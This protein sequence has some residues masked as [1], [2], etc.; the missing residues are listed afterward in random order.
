[1]VLYKARGEWQYGRFFVPVS[2][3]QIK[4]LFWNA[5]ALDGEGDFAEDL[6]FEKV[7]KALKNL[8]SVQVTD[9]KTLAD[10]LYAGHMGNPSQARFCLYPL[11]GGANPIRH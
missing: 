3:D 8:G 7:K 2:F 1:M 11:T 9:E 5:D 6:A 10:Y 4:P